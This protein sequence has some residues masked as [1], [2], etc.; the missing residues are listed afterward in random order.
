M[1]DQPGQGG[2]PP[3]GQPQQQPQQPQQQPPP[4]AQGQPPAGPVQGGP[5][6]MLQDDSTKVWLLAIF[7]CGIYA[8]IWYYR[9]AK[10][11]G[12]WSQGQIETDPTTSVLAVTLGGCLIV[13][14]YISWAGTL[15]RIRTV[16]QMVGLEPKAEFLPWFGYMFLAGYGYKWLQ[17]QLNEIA[18]RA[19]RP[20]VG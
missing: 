10:E 4:A 20:A 8:A 14:P 18:E 16:Q 19:P 2:P 17:D 12:E 13:P 15:G 3:E 5:R 1:Q 6:M 9:L 11:L 7:T